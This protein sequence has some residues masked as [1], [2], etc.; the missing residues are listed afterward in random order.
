MGE[1]KHSLNFGG[2]LRSIWGPGGYIE[3]ESMLKREEASEH[4]NEILV[5]RGE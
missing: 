2:G 5:V 4:K 3:G 1:H